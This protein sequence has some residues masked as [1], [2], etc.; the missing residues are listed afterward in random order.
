MP[1]VQPM[2]AKSVTGVP[3]A[4]SVDGG[5]VYEPKWDGFRAIVFRDGDEVEIGSRSTKPLT[6]Y[7]PEVV[8][9]VLENLPVRCV[10]DGEIVVPC[11]GHLEF[12][13]LTQRIHPAESRVRKL[14]E[15]SPA[16]LV[17]FDLLALG[18]ESYV[19]RPLSER[20]AALADALADASPPV[21]LTRTTTDSAEAADWFNVFEG[22]GLDGIVAKPLASPYM[23]NGRSM[24][25]VK[26]ARTADVVVA[27]YRLHKN[28]TEARPLLGSILLGLYAADGRLQH[29]GVCASFPETRRAA[30]VD[31][32]APLV[33]DFADHPWGEWRDEAAQA[34]GRLPGGQSRWTGT[35]DLSFVP[36]RPERVAEVGYEHM[37]GRGDGARFRHTAQ[38]KRW[39]DDREPESCGYAQLEEVASYDLASVLG[40][41]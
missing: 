38:F 29:V 24:L 36:L 22:A 33:T 35:K 6:R 34:S 10:V 14:A 21:H 3:P 37:E 41:R 25:K 1:P 26:H 18:D 17:V 11:D 23:M 12:D 13:L 30:L 7:F 16:H 15:E 4:D 27:G 5:L 40:I 31:E 20:R 2:L 28:S 19:E 9:A 39:R 8:A 32:F